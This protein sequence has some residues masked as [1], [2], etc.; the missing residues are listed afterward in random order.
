L[1]VSSDAVRPR[2]C[3]PAGRRNLLTVRIPRAEGRYR[4][5]A[6][7]V[8]AAPWL[9][10]AAAIMLTEGLVFAAYGLIAWLVWT[11]LP[12]VAVMAIGAAAL[13]RWRERISEK[14]R[15][16]DYAL[17]PDCMYPVEGDNG[18]CPECGAPFRL[19]EVVEGWLRSRFA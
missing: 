1:V 15:R 5:M 14:L 16:A 17:C 7:I 9:W 8:I 10:L 13:S 3:G 18:N 4:L 6:A 11:T 19:H 12:G 2:R